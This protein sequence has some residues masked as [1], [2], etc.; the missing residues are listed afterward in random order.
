M[1]ATLEVPVLGAFRK[2][3]I[4][5]AT[6]DHFGWSTK[7]DSGRCILLRMTRPVWAISHQCNYRIWGLVSVEERIATEHMQ[8]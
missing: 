4:S 2:S 3:L 7:V 8:A 1:F 6:L 5:K